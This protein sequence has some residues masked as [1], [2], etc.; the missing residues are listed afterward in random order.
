MTLLD[1]GSTGGTVVNGLQI[2]GHELDHGDVL[3]IGR[4]EF[5][6]MAPKPEA[7]AV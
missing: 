6:M 5:T 4:S 3:S 2:G 7:V 1:V